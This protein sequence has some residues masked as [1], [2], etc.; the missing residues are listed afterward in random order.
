MQVGLGYKRAVYAAYRREMMRR[1]KEVQRT[2]GGAKVSAA[3]VKKIRLTPKVRAMHVPPFTLPCCKR[4]RGREKRE[5]QTQSGIGI[6]RGAEGGTEGRRERGRK[7]E[8][9]RHWAAGGG[10][11]GGG[12]D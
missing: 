3:D 8:S 5:R 6:G 12:V 1:I 4:G 2:A 10:G 7:G 11:G 9:R